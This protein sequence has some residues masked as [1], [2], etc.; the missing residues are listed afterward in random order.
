MSTD[1][2]VGEIV[3]ITSG[4]GAGQQRR[5]GSNTATAITIDA[6]EP[7]FSPAPVSPS[8]SRVPSPPCPKPSSPACEERARNFRFNGFPT[9]TRE[10]R[11]AF[12]P[13][14]FPGGPGGDDSGGGGTL[15]VA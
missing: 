5:I 1:E 4:T 13:Q 7:D 3:R 8:V 15:C 11:Q 12:Q 6:A 14:E 9:L 2:H 10:L